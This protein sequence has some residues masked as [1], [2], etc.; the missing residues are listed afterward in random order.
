MKLRTKIACLLLTGLVIAA[1]W[2]TLVPRIRTASPAE[3]RTHA[4]PE[5]LQPVLRPAGGGERFSAYLQAVQPLV[6]RQ[7][8]E[9]PQV[10]GYRAT[11]QVTEPGGAAR[12]RDPACQG[13]WTGQ[14]QEPTSSGYG[15]RPG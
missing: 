8:S 11:F 2:W 10:P 4:A 6:R 7:R 9:R 13:H 3:V 5:L 15:K 1:G 12:A 14:M